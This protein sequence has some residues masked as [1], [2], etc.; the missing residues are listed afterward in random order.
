M[1]LWIFFE[2]LFELCNVA[3]AETLTQIIGAHSRYFAA[4]VSPFKPPRTISGSTTQTI[5]AFLLY[6]YN[7]SKWTDLSPC[8]KLYGGNNG[9]KRSVLLCVPGLNCNWNAHYVRQLAF[10]CESMGIACAVLVRSDADV[11]NT[12]ELQQGIEDLKHHFS[13]LGIVGISAGG[14]IACRYLAK[15]NEKSWIKFCM[16]VSNGFDLDETMRH[17]PFKWSCLLAPGYAGVLTRSM[18]WY[19]SIWHAHQYVASQL[20]QT[21]CDYHEMRGSIRHLK[22]CACYSKIPLVVV[23]S[24]DDP[25]FSGKHMFEH[26]KRAIELSK[27]HGN[28]AIT[29]IITS[30]GGHVGWNKKLVGRDC[31]WLYTDVLPVICRRF[32]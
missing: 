8:V 28:D 25:F 26:I 15:E 18:N 32:L 21:L 4:R 23:S 20:G 12:A 14:N 3:P 30:H 7:R 29:A 1:A 24:M 5:S 13:S 27:E 17:M 16:V 11:G 2:C 19:M 31:S 6:Q 10:A 9:G 22:E